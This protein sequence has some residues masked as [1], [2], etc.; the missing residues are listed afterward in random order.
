MPL[1][2]GSPPAS[3]AARTRSRRDHGRRCT[4]RPSA[5]HLEPGRGLLLRA[6]HRVG[7]LHGERRSRPVTTS[8]AMSRMS[9]ARR[10]CG[11]PCTRNCSAAASSALFGRERPVCCR[12]A[13]NVGRLT[14][15]PGL[16]KHELLDQVG[17]RARRGAR[18]HGAAGARRRGTGSRCSLRRH[19][20]L[21]HTIVTGVPFGTQ[22][23]WL[24]IKEQRLA[25]GRDP[26]SSRD[27][28]GG[29]ARRRWPPGRTGTR[30]R[31][32]AP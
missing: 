1:S 11:A 19:P 25:V 7:D 17:G 15:S 28:L 8:T 31:R 18:R 24:S 30:R 20:R 23:A 10:C 5:A 3:T 2:S 27:P 22:T 21:G 6:V 26:W 4:A 16:V 14:R 32:G 9:C 12:P 13:P 29:D